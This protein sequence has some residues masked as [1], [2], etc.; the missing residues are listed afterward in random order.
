MA[1]K[2]C[3]GVADV[4]S[5]MSNFVRPS[6]PILDKYPNR[7]KNHKLEGVVLV[8]EDMKF[9]QKGSDAIPVFVFAHTNFPEK[10][11]YAAKQYIHVAQEGT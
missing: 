5:V 7:S 10:Q 8:E 4:A 11:F 9:M 6:N 3:A 2:L 1:P